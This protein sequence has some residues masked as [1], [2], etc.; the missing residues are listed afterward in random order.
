[1]QKAE[2]FKVQKRNVVNPEQ[3]SAFD[4]ISK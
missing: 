2:L 1:M 4:A 3:L